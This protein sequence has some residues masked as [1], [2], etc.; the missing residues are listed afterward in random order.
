MSLPFAFPLLIDVR[1]PAR[2]WGPASI[3]DTAAA[4]RRVNAALGALAPDA[5][6][7]VTV[8]DPETD[9][10]V[11]VQSASVWPTDEADA[12]HWRTQCA[13]ATALLLPHVHRAVA[14]P[15]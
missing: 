3:P 10:V 8:D 6:T 11:H 5:T 7:S 4:V 15:E 12:R 9:I 14:G 13:M 2:G 1:I